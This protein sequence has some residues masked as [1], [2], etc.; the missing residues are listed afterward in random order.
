M[1]SS[2]TFDFS[3]RSMVNGNLDALVQYVTSLSS[4]KNSPNM[5]SLSS[6]SKRFIG[7]Y[8]W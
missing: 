3:K 5:D 4:K 8:T 1:K 2:K 7:I 6:K